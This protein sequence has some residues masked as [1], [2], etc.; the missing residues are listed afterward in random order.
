MPGDVTAR[1]VVL[2]AVVVWGGVAL[3][4]IAFVILMVIIGV[5]PRWY[6]PVDNRTVIIGGLFALGAAV[7]IG[8]TVVVI[9]L[10]RGGVRE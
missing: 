5:P 9:R 8:A 7:A 1:R 3:L 2:M 4:G 6:G 10:L